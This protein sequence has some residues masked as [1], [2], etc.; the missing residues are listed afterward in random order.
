MAGGQRDVLPVVSLRLVRGGQAEEQQ[1]RA[2]RGGLLRSPEQFPGGEGCCRGVRQRIPGLERQ[3]G[4]PAPQGV[5][6]IVQAGRVH[7]RRSGPLIS[8]GAG[9][10]PDDHD[11][12]EPGQGER[13]PFVFKQHGASRCGLAGQ[14]VVGPEIEV[15]LGCFPVV[16]GDQPQHARDGPV[17]VGFVQGACPDGLGDEPVVPAVRGRHFQVQPGGDSCDTVV[18]R[19]SVGHHQPVEAPFLT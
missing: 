3:T 10:L 1:D 14:F 9:H 5:E 18:D 8:G 17:Q 2:A 16:P 19:P 15:F 12:T 4:V 7:L 6:G 11:V 13:R